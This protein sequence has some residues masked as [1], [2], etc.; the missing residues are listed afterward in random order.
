MN[1]GLYVTFVNIPGKTGPG[2]STED[3]RMN[4]MTPLSK[5]KIQNLSH[6]GLKPST[7]PFGYRVSPEYQTRVL[8]LA[9]LRAIIVVFNPFYSRLE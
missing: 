3:D 1:E 9:L 2:D 7:L 6:G 5:H 4:Q 8:T